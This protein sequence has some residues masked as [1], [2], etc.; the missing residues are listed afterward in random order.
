[1]SRNN[2]LIVIGLTGSLGTGKSTVAKMFAELGAKVVDADVIA[3]RLMRPGAICFRRIVKTFGK[4]IL[5]AGKIDRKKMAEQVFRNPRQLRKLERI[6]HP[7]VRRALLAKVKQYKKRKQRTVVVL[8]VPL[9]FEAKLDQDVDRTVVVKA[10]K[11]NQ[12]TRAKKLMN[13]TNAAAQRRIK[14][15]MPLRQK[16]RLADLI[17][18][19]D[20]TLKQT[21]LKVKQIWEK[22]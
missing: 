9:L 12:I 19:N 18:D 13:I 8:D 1:M 2:K 15:Q 17:I 22:L 20:G 11:A 7:E 4:D 6:V 14:A 16:I 3:R 21:K 5:T 10:S